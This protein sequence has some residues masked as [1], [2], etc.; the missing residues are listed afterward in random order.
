MAGSAYRDAMPLPV[1]VATYN[2]YLGADLSGLFGDVP[3]EELVGLVGEVQRQLEATAFATRAPRIA[4]AIAGEQVDLV[5]L[6]EVCTWCQ[7]GELV[8]DYLQ[9]LL[10]ALA[11]EG[12]PY[13]LVSE[14]PSFRGTGE[15]V[16]DGRPVTLEL[17]GRNVVIARKGAGIVVE[18]TDAGLFGAALE[19]PLMGSARVRLERGWCSARCTVDGLTFAFVN[20]HTEAYDPT[21]RNDQRTELLKVLPPGPLV[22]VGDFNATPDE[23][24]MPAELRDAWVEAGGSDDPA[25][26][27]TCCQ[28]ADLTNAESRLTE[29]IDYVWVRGLGVESCFRTGV[30]AEDCPGR[31]LWP[32]DPAGV[33]ATL[34]PEEPTPE[35]LKE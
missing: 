12:E 18:G 33:V 9:M 3:A 23:V 5:G 4:K 19:L 1:R 8:S 21:S 16:R 13:V 28:G 25:E 26:A 29:R 11:D 14:Q 34:V 24:G 35:V 2:L 32:S 7:D 31:G 6:Q 30:H 17:R 27:A 22:L 20:T 15:V 10:D